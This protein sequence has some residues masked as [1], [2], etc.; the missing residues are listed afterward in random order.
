MAGRLQHKSPDESVRFDTMVPLERDAYHRAQERRKTA[1]EADVARR[2]KA[3]A[4]LLAL[5]SESVELQ[6]DGP[7]WCAKTELTWARHMG[8]L[9][10]HDCGRV[11]SE[12]T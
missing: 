3:R 1:H 8:P 2:N 10:C 6:G 7:C 5:R 4:E 9:V 12:G 11:I